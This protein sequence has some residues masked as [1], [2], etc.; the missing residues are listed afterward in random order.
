MIVLSIVEREL[1]VASRRS[2]TYWSRF[3][4]VLAALV[5]V[6][7]VIAGPIPFPSISRMGQH[8][9]QVLAYLSFISVVI[10]AARLTA[11]CLSA[12]KREGT[13]GFLFLTDLKPADVV[14]GKVAATSLAAFYGL[15]ALVPVIAIPLL[16]GGVTFMDVLRLALV[17]INALFFSL[18]LSMFISAVSWHERKAVGM[19]LLLLFA[20]MAGIPIAFVVLVSSNMAVNVA[21]VLAA[22]SP[23]TPL[24]IVAMGRY[25]LMVTPFWVSVGVTHVIAWLLLFATCRV[26][27]RVWQDRPA[28]GAWFRWRQFCRRA[29]LGKAALQKTFRRQLLD[30]NPIYWLASRERRAVWHPWVF[31]GSMALLSGIICWLLR[32]RGVELG[33]LLTASFGLNWF[34]KHWIANIACQ[35]FS[36]DRDKGALELLLS[37]PVTVPGMIRGYWMGLRRVFLVPLV[38][39]NAVEWLCF[40]IGVAGREAH[41]G[42]DEFV[43][44]AMVA[45]VV[46]QVVFYA[47][48][49][50]LVWAGWWSGVVSR[51]TST[52]ISTV[53]F[54]LM[55]L[56]WLV[57][58]L[59]M[60]PVTRINLIPE[61][62]PYIA[63]SLYAAASIWAD[64]FFGKN[65]R[66]KLLT[67]L[68]SAAVERYSGSDVSMRWWRLVGQALGR[69]FAGTHVLATPKTA[70]SGGFQTGPGT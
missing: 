28:Q 26:L 11:D 35:T 50:A 22:F 46:G 64:L 67:E 16:C 13:L 54:R 17:L 15:L 41:S 57:V 6:V 7:F 19:A 48:L 24:G 4:A 25:S 34:F 27:P 18:A 32:L 37:T 45:F 12:E 39:L 5:P 31:L 10:A 69:R 33:V 21:H 52:A 66:H 42:P 23:G 20:I 60:I 61:W 68:R 43:E 56:P 3:Q 47:D 49:F 2:A 1:R 55:I 14:F 38:A 36:T 58:V 29:L 40:G 9:F 53:Y 44:F 30:L 65:A 63:L 59:G 62:T 51:N 8:T 70:P